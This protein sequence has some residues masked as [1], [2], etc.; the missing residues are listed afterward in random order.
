MFNSSIV[1]YTADLFVENVTLFSFVKHLSAQFM[2]HGSGTTLCNSLAE[3]C[4]L[5]ITRIDRWCPTVIRE[6]IGLQ[7]SLATVCENVEIELG[8]TCGQDERRTGARIGTTWTPD[9]LLE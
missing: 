2:K 5:G 1:E 3:R 6:N 9:V 8:R 4:I 7:D